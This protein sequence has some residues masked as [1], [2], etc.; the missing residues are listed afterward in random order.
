MQFLTAAGTNDAYK[1]VK[2]ATDSHLGVPSQCLHP[3]KA[4]IGMPPR[5]GRGQYCGNVVSLFF[6]RLLFPVVRRL[7]L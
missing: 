3:L 6:C 5:R 2:R 1:E 7:S 4:S